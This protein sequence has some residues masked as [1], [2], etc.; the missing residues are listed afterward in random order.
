MMRFQLYFFIKNWPIINIEF[1]TYIDS[2]SISNT[3]N[4]SENIDELNNVSIPNL[5]PVQKSD[6]NENVW[7]QITRIPSNVGGQ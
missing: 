4:Y 6:E 5:Y 1:V 7:T 3:T 2:L